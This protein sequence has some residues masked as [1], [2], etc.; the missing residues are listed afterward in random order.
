ML[1]DAMSDDNLC[2]GDIWMGITDE[3]GENHFLNVSRYSYEDVFI[4]DQ[5]VGYNL[6]NT[7][8]DDHQ[9][10]GGVNENCVVSY[11]KAEKGKSW[12]DLNCNFFQCVA[13]TIRANQF[14][15]IRG[16]CKNTL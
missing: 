13:C 12:R 10:N 8:W 11:P 1:W 15:Q 7:R 9:P 2:Q 16:L 5:D 3:Q 4:Y 6:S 14:Y